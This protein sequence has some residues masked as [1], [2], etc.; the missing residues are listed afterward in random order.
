M[1]L[2]ARAISETALAIDSAERV[3]MSSELLKCLERGS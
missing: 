3:T 2:V 1:R